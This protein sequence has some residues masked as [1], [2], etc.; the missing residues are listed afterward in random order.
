MK[1]LDAFVWQRRN[2]LAGLPL[3]AALASTWRE[4]EADVALW[5]LRL[6]WS[7]LASPFV[8]GRAATAGMLNA[9]RT[10]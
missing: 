7:A 10:V 3:A 4:V 8:P 2:V 5:P 9:D 1:H 6:R